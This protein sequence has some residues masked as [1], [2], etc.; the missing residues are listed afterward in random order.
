MESIKISISLHCSGIAILLPVSPYNNTPRMQFLGPSVSQHIQF[1][2]YTYRHGLVNYIRHQSKLSS[3]KNIDLYRDFAAGVFLS[4]FIDWRP[5]FVNSCL[6]NLISGSALPH[7][8]S[9][10]VNTVYC[11]YTYTVCKGGGWG[12]RFWASDRNT[13]AAKSIYS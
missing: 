7:P 1:Y 11:I 9:P 6:S 5:S 12:T 4:E 8:P 10:L 3:Y 13:P 2:S